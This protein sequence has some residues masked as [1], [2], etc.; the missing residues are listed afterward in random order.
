VVL[1]GLDSRTFVLYLLA[2]VELLPD[3][4]F[5]DVDWLDIPWFGAFFKLQNIPLI[6]VRR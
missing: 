4:K 6:G 5:D 3:E 1:Q 2:I